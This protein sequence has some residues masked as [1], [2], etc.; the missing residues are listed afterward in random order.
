MIEPDARVPRSYV[1]RPAPD[2][3]PDEPA[4]PE[5]SARDLRLARYRATATVP[6]GAA[7]AAAGPASPHRLLLVATVLAGIPAALVLGATLSVLF[8]TLTLPLG[9]PGWW[10]RGSWNLV[11]TTF[12][13]GPW[14]AASCVAA[15]VLLLVELARP[16]P[17][18]GWGRTAA[19]GRPAVAL[20]GSTVGLVALVPLIA[21]SGFMLFLASAYVCASSA[22]CW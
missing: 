22:A 16:R 6:G 20:M 11:V 8:T 5:L 1:T 13:L 21:V 14:L 15:V 3:V 10:E 19:R 17:R 9:L 4:A 2:V 18:D 7:A 12:M